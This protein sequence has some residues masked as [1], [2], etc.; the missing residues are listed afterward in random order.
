[1]VLH[2]K[3]IVEKRKFEINCLLRRNDINKITKHQLTG[4]LNEVDFFLKTLDDYDQGKKD[5]T[6]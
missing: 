6:E 4:A 3:R 5:N 2:I 1:M